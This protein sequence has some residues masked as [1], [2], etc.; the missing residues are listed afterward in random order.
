MINFCKSVVGNTGK[1]KKICR[2]FCTICPKYTYHSRKKYQPAVLFCGCGGTSMARKWK[3]GCTDKRPRT[4]PL[5]RQ[6][7]FF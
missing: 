1:N 4:T 7:P 5:I 3:G 2:K 6:S